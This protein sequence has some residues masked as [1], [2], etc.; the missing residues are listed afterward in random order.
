MTSIFKEKKATDAAAFLLY[1]NGGSMN[2]MKLIK[3]LYFADREALIKWGRPITFDNYF[4][5]E[6][7][8]VLSQVFDLIN[9]NLADQNNYWYELISEPKHYELN[10]LKESSLLSLSDAEIDLLTELFDKY[11]KVSEWD[12]V[13]ITHD[14][15]PEWQDSG[16]SAIPIDIRDILNTTDK[17]EIEKQ[18]IIDE[19]EEINTFE[20]H[21]SR[22]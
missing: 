9:Y 3:I 13:K 10:L 11:K 15:L 16:K 14:T 12:M 20:E 22:M 1:L 2:Y 7:G 17:T 19:L 5:M 6:R 8:P 21:K 18:A 4:S